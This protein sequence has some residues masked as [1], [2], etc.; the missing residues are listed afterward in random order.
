MR[1]LLTGG[2]G[3]I[4]SFTTKML[5]DEGFDV[6]VLDNLERGFKESVD[7]RAVLFVGDIR[8]EDTIR[9]LFENNKFD[10]VIHFAGF[11]SVEE[12]EKN[13]ELYRE[14]NIIGS[15][16]LFE[17]AYDVGK[18]RKFVFSSSAAVYGNPIKIPIPEDHPTNPT[19]VYGETK[20]A[21]E[22]SLSDMGRQDSS[23]GYA[24]LRYFNAS[25]ASLDGA[26]GERHDPETH[27][28]PLALKSL[29]KGSEFYLYGTDY[30]T[31]DGSCIRDYIHVL[32]LARAHILALE[33][34]NK[35]TSGYIYNVGSGKGYSNEEVIDAIEKI[36][37]KKINLVVKER[38]EGDPEVLIADPSKIN[39][40]LNFIPQYSDLNTIVKSA[41]EWHSKKF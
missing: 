28:I 33:K 32:D 25:G 37:G 26:N 21:T 9:K 7:P 34:I 41:W 16:N 5:L 13:P 40:E 15:Q 4:G 23:I 29:I 2:A 35:E 8:D 3:Y 20:L 27:I 18:V 38:R 24:C 6:V 14:N 19:S 31:P 10:S 22:R 36:T 11:I 39:S 1:I 30:S 12:S 17:K